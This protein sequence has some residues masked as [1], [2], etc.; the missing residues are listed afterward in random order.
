[1][2]EELL[3]VAASYATSEYNVRNTADNNLV[4]KKTWR[5]ETATRLPLDLAHP[6][7]FR[8]APLRQVMDGYFGS[9]FRPHHVYGQYRSNIGT[10]QHDTPILR[11]RER[12]RAR[13]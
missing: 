7:Y 4:W 8:D 5:R 3:S 6:C 9:P 2:F 13:E 11:V 1:M 10:S 12:E